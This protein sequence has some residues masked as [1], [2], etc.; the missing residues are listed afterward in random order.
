MYQYM[1]KGK[2]RG[3]VFYTPILSWGNY[4]SFDEIKP[5]KCLL[6]QCLARSK[7]S[8]YGYYFDLRSFLTIWDSVFSFAEMGH[9]W[10]LRL[11]LANLLF[12]VGIE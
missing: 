2:E 1:D 9:R 10:F 11:L 8:T 3:A 5:F 4:V 12:Q 6:A 7:H